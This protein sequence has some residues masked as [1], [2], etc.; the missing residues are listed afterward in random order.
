MADRA[1][2][3][4]GRRGRTKRVLRLV[5]LTRKR[6]R[7]AAISIV[8]VRDAGERRQQEEQRDGT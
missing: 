4:L 3:V 7:A 2:L 8:E 6:G 1:V 5:V